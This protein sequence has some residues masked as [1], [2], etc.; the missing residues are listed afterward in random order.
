[1]ILLVEMYLLQ[2]KICI[3]IQIEKEELQNRPS[4]L[5]DILESLSQSEVVV[6]LN[7]LK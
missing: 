4:F 3:Y 2:I 6:L 7:K 1:M 5:K